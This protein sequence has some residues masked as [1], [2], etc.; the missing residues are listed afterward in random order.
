MFCLKPLGMREPLAPMD[1][2]FKTLFDRFFGGWPVPFEPNMNR[3]GVWELKV[4]ETEKEFFVRAEAPGFEPEDFRV[5]VRGALL[6]LKAEH[7]HEAKEKKEKYEWAEERE[8]FYERYVTLP[9]ATDPEKVEAH[10]RN[11]VLEVHLPKTEEVKT[12]LI[13]V[14]T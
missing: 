1:A 7:K 3:A 12:R 6:M 14:K 5:E 9:A 4:E 10:Y 11:G 2:E 13:P 8:L